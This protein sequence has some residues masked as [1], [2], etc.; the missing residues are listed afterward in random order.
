L[1]AVRNG[2]LTEEHMEHA[3]GRGMG[4]S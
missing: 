1:H 4:K 3:Y 2:E